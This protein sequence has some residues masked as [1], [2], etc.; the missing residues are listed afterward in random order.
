MFSYISENIDAYI[1]YCKYHGKHHS[2]PWFSAAWIATVVS[3]R[4]KGGGIG[5]GGLVN[6]K[7][8]F[9]VGFNSAFIFQLFSNSSIVLIHQS[10]LLVHKNIKIL[11]LS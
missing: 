9:S 10:I 6:V 1:P 4:E 11:L 5:G 8:F 7:F 2:F 3:K